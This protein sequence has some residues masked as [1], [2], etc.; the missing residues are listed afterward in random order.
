MSKATICPECDAEFTPTP[1]AIESCQACTN[2]TS[3]CDRRANI[4]RRYWVVLVGGGVLRVE[5]F[6]TGGDAMGAC[7]A[8]CDDNGG[9]GWMWPQCREYL[10]AELVA[11]VEATIANTEAMDPF[12]VTP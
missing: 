3:L 8:H 2:V 1:M 4:G 6:D 10:P 12:A 5:S 7:M 11:V 9:K